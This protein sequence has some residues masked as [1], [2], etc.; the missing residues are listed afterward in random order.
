[1]IEYL[2]YYHD[3]KYIFCLC[4]IIIKLF[5]I[6]SIFKVLL[7]G[8]QGIILGSTFCCLPYIIDLMVYIYEKT[9]SNIYFPFLLWSLISIYFGYILNIFYLGIINTFFANILCMI[10]LIYVLDK[11]NKQTNIMP[12]I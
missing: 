8:I 6:S 12:A 1:M 11:I 4:I 3:K 9:R 7:F 2:N 10:Y 5:S